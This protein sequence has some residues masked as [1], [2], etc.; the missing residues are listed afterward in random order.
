MRVSELKNLLVILIVIAAGIVWFGKSNARE[1]L[2]WDE[3]R[4]MV[5]GNAQAAEWKLQQEEGYYSGCVN[6]GWD[7]V[8]Q[9]NV[10]CYTDKIDLDNARRDRDAAKKKLEELPPKPKLYFNGY[11]L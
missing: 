5:E 9:T 8:A 6:M 7:S 11:F 3:E 10:E 1:F 2:R 4:A